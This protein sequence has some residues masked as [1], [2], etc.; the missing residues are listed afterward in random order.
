M[1]WWHWMPCSSF[2]ECWVLS[3]LFHSPL[4][5][6]KKT[7]KTTA[8]AY[9]LSVIHKALYHLSLS[10]SSY[11]LTH[12]TPVTQASLL[13][14]ELTRHAPATGPLFPL[15][16]P[17]F[18]HPPSWLLPHLLQ[19][20]AQMDLSHKGPFWPPSSS[21]FTIIIIF[22]LWLCKVFFATCRLLWL[23]SLVSGSIIA[24]CR[25][26]CYT[27][28]W[29]LSSSTIGGTRFPCIGKRILNHWTTREILPS[30]ND[31]P[32]PLPF[33][34]LLFSFLCIILLVYLVSCLSHLLECQFHEGRESIFPFVYIFSF[35]YCRVP[36]NSAGH[37]VGAQ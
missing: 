10:P 15:P 34:P 3:Q 13:F 35:V 1:K 25:R 22:L 7:T 6:S 19:I 36:Y 21:S 4:S 17:L 2:F 12:C 33:P 29:D 37:I 11:Q 28:M 32:L 16:G 30:V 8:K 14:L 5:L 20:F 26:S 9:V 23:W 27:A 18:S 24:T 31:I